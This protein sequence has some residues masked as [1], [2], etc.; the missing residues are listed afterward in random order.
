LHWTLTDKLGTVREVVSGSTGALENHLEYDEHGSIL[1][2]LGGSGASIG[3]DT[4]VV[5]AAFAGREFVD[6]PGAMPT[7]QG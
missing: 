5:D 4:R 1:R 6:E 7:R 2:V 3:I